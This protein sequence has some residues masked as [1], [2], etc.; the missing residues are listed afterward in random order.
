MS[1][2]ECLN[3]VGIFISL[4][5]I[6]LSITSLV[7]LF[8]VNGAAKEEPSYRDKYIKFEIVATFDGVKSDCIEN[9]QTFLDYGTFEFSD[10]RMKNIKKYSLGLIVLN[11]I[12]LGIDILTIIIILL[13][14]IC[15][16][17]SDTF[18]FVIIIMTILKLL[19][20]LIAFIFFI[21][22][23]VNY[24]KSDFV[25]FKKFSGCSY[26]NQDFAPD[27]EFVYDVKVYYKKYF[28]LYFVIF[29]LNIIDNII[30]RLKKKD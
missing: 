4:A 23:S 6:A 12:L 7:W 18:A 26:L 17:R 16:S 14:V 28:I 9:Y 5:I 24:F 29:A 13:V 10:I 8:K 1:N 27:Y 3:I 25:K 30:S 20:A 19:A 15:E 11:F 2:K 22:L 21:I